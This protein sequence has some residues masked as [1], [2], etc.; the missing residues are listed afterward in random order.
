MSNARRLLRV[1]AVAGIVLAIVVGTRVVAEIVSGDRMFG[2]V[3]SGLVAAVFAVAP[4]AMIGETRRI[5]DM[6]RS[7]AGDATVNR[8]QQEDAAVQRMISAAGFAAAI[9]M[10]NATSF[11]FAVWFAIFAVAIIGLIAQSSAIER[12]ELLHPGAAFAVF[13]VEVA[14]VAM[15]A[16]ADH[17]VPAVVALAALVPAVVY[18]VRRPASVR[19]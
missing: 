5:L 2:L 19:A 1:A 10:L 18:F 16:N 9:G 4:L 17:H 8:A 13:L 14:F 3:A 12:A 11:G 15:M 7:W 6:T